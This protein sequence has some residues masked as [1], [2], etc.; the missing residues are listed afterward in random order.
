MVL[1][2]LKHLLLESVIQLKSETIYQIKSKN[3]IKFR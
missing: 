3:K 1:V 2:M